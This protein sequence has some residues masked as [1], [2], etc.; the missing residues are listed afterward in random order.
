M[1]VRL[2]RPL[3]DD[4][5]PRVEALIEDVSAFIVEYCTGAWDRDNPPALF[6]AVAAAEVIR[7]L[8][9]TPGV[10]MEKTGELE[11]QFGASAGVLGLSQ[12][13]KDALSRYRRR[14]GTITTT[15]T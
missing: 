4:E 6:G 7:G 12:P 1:A 5:A 2:G 9:V 10:L 8:S 14:V 11:V 3:A 15:R 13:A